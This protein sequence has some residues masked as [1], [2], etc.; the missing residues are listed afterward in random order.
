MTPQKVIRTYLIIAA[1]YTLSA[2][3]I[4]GVNTLFLLDAGLDILGVFIANAAFSAGMAIFEIPT[5]VL[6]DTGG[7][8]LSFL[9]SVIVLFIGTL[10]YAGIAAAGGGIGWFVAASI[11]LGLGYTFYSGAVEAWLVD[12]LN[13][14]GYEGRLDQIFARGSMV[15]GAAMLLGTVVGGF[16]GDWDLSVPFVGRAILLAVVFGIAYVLMHDIGYTKHTLTWTTFPAQMK[17]VTQASLTYGWQ[18]RPIRLLIIVS[19]IQSGFMAWGFYAWPPYFQELLGT[20]AVWIAGVVTA[21]IALSTIV[22]NT[23]VEWFAHRPG[24][25][26]TLLLA[27]ACV[28]TVAIVGLGLAGSFW[29]ALPLLLITT[30]AM[31][32]A[33]P[34]QQAFMHQLIPSE[35]RA[36][37]VS[38]NSMIAN[39]GGFISQAGL[40]SLAQT[41]SIAT[42]YVSGG[43]AILLALPV[44][45]TL[46]RLHSPA[47]Q[48]EGDV[49]AKT[50]CA[51]QGLPEITAVETSIDVH[52]ATS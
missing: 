25:R 28:Q 4:W 9:F 43:L 40:G 35:Q 7:R 36:T 41:R 30:M 45:F 37:I 19:F 13:A 5:G 50:S 49:G 10:G 44:L 12:A 21:L 48:I 6:A 39:G 3:L 51:G 11:V 23:I 46:Q 34:V 15:T 33:G 31:G 18:K 20:E 32:A 42:G 1:L 2:S 26:T 27:A 47:D 38:F 22:G 52:V 17:K 8:R 29:V 24:R 16:L 14:T